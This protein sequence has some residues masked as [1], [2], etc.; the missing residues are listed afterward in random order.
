MEFRKYVH[1]ACIPDLNNNFSNSFVN[2]A[3]GP[4]GA[5]PFDHKTVTNRPR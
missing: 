3:K 5:S 2:K 1:H 4:P